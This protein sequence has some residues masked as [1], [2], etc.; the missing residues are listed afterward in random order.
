MGYEKRISESCTKY[1]Q[2]LPRLQRIAFSTLDDLPFILSFFEQYKDETK[3]KYYNDIIYQLRSISFI[4]CLFV[5]IPNYGELHHEEVKMRSRYQN[6]ANLL[7]QKASNNLQV[8]K[9]E[10]SFFD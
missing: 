5:S 6:I 2:I 1:M 4:N 8:L 9:L 3:Q 10:N 7:L